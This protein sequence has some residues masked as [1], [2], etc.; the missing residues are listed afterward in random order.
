MVVGPVDAF[1]PITEGHAIS[2]KSRVNVLRGLQQEVDSARTPSSSSAGGNPGHGPHVIKDLVR[3]AV[4]AG[5]I[6]RG[7]VNMHTHEVKS[8]RPSFTEG[9]YFVRLG[10]RRG[11]TL[12]ILAILYRSASGVINAEDRDVFLRIN[13]MIGDTGTFAQIGSATLAPVKLFGNYIGYD[14][15]GGNDSAFA[16]SKVSSAFSNSI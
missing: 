13:A 2:M 16:R 8:K 7:G 12:L 1:G 4:N 14:S 15:V 3:Y 11:N 5:T 9:C 6:K 10:S